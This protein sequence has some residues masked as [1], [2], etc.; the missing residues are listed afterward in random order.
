[1]SFA[2]PHRGRLFAAALAVTFAFAS[3]AQPAAA[4]PDAPP[5]WAEPFAADTAAIAAAAAEL[6]PAAEGGRVL[7]EEIVVRYDEDGR[8]EYR[9]REVVRI[10]SQAAVSSWNDLA[11]QWRPWHQERP[12]L[13]V[14]VI[15]A[16]G[17]VRT[18][19]PATV[20]EVPV[21]EQ[22]VRVISDAR[23]LRAP[24]PGLAVG[25]VLES[26]VT[27]RDTKPLFEAGVVGR[28]VIG[29]GVPVEATRLVLDAPASLPLT[30]RAWKVGD[31]VPRRE[32]ADGRVRLVFDLGPSEPRSELEAWT[33]GDVRQRPTVAWATGRSWQEV[34][35]AY[36]GVVERQ[37]DGVDVA[38]VAAAATRGVDGRAARVAALVAEL[39]RRV[40][41]TGLEF[42]EAAIVP[43]PPAETLKRGYGDCKDKSALLVALLQEAGVDAHLALL[44]AG[45]GED[46]H[47]ELPGF[48]AFNHAVVHVPA[49]GD[50][51]AIWID[52]TAEWYPVGLVP[53]SVQGRLALLA[54]PRDG[55]LVEVPRAT[56]AD[57]RH[58]AER[59]IRFAEDGFGD[60]VERIEY[61]GLAA[62]DTRG[63]FQSIS[64]DARRE[65]VERYVESNWHRDEVADWSLDALAEADRP[66]SFDVEIEEAPPV[67]TAFTESV[68]FLDLGSVLGDLPTT[69]RVDPEEAEPREHDLVITEPYRREVRYR[70]V[71]ANGFVPADVPEDE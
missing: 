68:A 25:T 24:A 56:S 39:H 40:R 44:D 52:A 67:I 4:Q 47:P 42:G 55:R 14:R 43:R 15:A 65:S 41:Y 18:L 10:E 7:L 23:R 16:D 48:G 17:T 35:A 58:R 19:D 45:Y 36:A 27:L 26:E 71:P 2:P 5:P 29:Y 31:P 13:R 53:S 49:A 37:L 38:E 8:Q 21:E 30:W 22:G 12:E 6:E 51:P 20:A 28:M 60:V 9:R 62:A 50:E 70:L 33:R 57:R 46:V 11:A 54:T 64:E 69:L 3:S 66:L 59:E 61:H 63:F 1:M 32:E 34:A